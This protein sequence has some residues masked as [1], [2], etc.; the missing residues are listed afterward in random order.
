MTVNCAAKWFSNTV[1]TSSKETATFKVTF[2]SNA[3][4][5][6]TYDLRN[7]KTPQIHLNE[8]FLKCNNDIKIS[9]DPYSSH[10]NAIC[11]F[12][13]NVYILE[14]SDCNKNMVH[15]FQHEGHLFTEEGSFNKNKVTSSI[16]WLPMCGS[17][18]LLSAANDGSIQGW[19]YIS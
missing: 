3:G 14:E 17:N 12:D 18:T 16:L 19:Q 4:T 9:F 1:Y 11:G 5:L 6:V 13:G 15:A 2:I 8:L 10:K 7:C